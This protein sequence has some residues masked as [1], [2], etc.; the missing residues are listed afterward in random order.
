[1]PATPRGLRVTPM[2]R[3]P[4]PARAYVVVAANAVTVLA[5]AAFV[6]AFGFTSPPEG[7]VPAE[8]ML[9]SHDTTEAIETRAADPT[10]FAVPSLG[11]EAD[12]IEL[13]KR[14]DGRLEVPADPATAGW[15]SGG[16]NPGERGAAVIVGHVDSYHGPGVFFDLEHIEVGASVTVDREDATRARFRVDRVETH[17]KDQFPTQAVYGHTDEP[18]LRLIT[19][20]GAFDPDER[21]YADNVIVFLELDEDGADAED[22]RSHANAVSVA[23]QVDGAGERADE[24]TGV[25][26]ASDRRAIPAALAALNLAVTAGVVWRQWRAG[27]P[28]SGADQ[29]LPPAA[30]NTC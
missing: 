26:S 24:A 17:P 25:R 20:A 10:G 14:D 6:A 23:A 19:C 5:L 4:V 28:S 21:S 8:P 7:L 22:D 12:T 18:T 27:R 11:I 30:P 9:P 29:S 13:G 16:V 2:G 3:R 15:W 1:M